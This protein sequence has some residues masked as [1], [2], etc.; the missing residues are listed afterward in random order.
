LSRLRAALS[1]NPLDK[2]IATKVDEATRSLVSA[3]RVCDEA[4]PTDALTRRGVSR[5]RQDLL[6]ALGALTVVRRITSP[7]DVGDSESTAPAPRRERRPV[8]SPEV[9]EEKGEG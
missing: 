3:L 2:A 4:R 6:R 7:Y 8:P 5:T 1:L 9:A